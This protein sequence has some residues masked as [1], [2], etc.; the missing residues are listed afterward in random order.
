MPLNALKRV[1]V[2]HVVPL[3]DMGRFVADLV[4]TY[5]GDVNRAFRRI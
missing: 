2:D 5:S 1:D 4:G 3:S